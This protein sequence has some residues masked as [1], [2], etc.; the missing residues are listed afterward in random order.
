MQFL[1]CSPSIQLKSKRSAIHKEWCQNR[2]SKCECTII[3]KVAALISAHRPISYLIVIENFKNSEH[4][5]GQLRK[6]NK[7]PTTEVFKIIFIYFG[8][9]SS[10]L[11]VLILNHLS[12]F[13]VLLCR[14]DILSFIRYTIFL[15]NERL[16]FWNCIL[17]ILNRLCHL[18]INRLWRIVDS[19]FV[20]SHDFQEVGAILEFLIRTL[21]NNLSFFEKNDS[22][23]MLQ[24][25]NCMSQ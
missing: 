19:L 13:W 8:T 12:W 7:L 23:Y 24:K 16:F 21:Q 14:D 20:N 9:D 17:N 22:V 2:V 25:V 11:D 5:H 3:S 1:S 10:L 4:Y 18:L 15:F 6:N